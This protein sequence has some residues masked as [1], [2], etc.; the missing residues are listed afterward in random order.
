MSVLDKIVSAL[1][2]PE[3]DEDRAE[4]RARAQEYAVRAPW[5]SMVLD[6]H[7]AIEAAFGSVMTAGDAAQRKQAL[8]ELGTLMTGHSLAEEGVIYPALSDTGETGHATMAYTEQSA[9]K[10]QLGLLERMDPMSDDFEDKFGHLEG[11]VKHH[12]YQEEGNWFIDLIDAAPATEHEMISRRYTEEF[13]RYMG[14]A[15]NS[16][17]RS[18]N[19]NDKDS[20]GMMLQDEGDYASTTLATQRLI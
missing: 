7:M 16:S 8:K 18:S 13:E 10:M 11:A 14:G 2:P 3:S 17:I 19:A 4:A 15:S 9:A 5:L 20:Q 1:T 12:V 6:H